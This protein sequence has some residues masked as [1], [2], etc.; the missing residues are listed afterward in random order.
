MSTSYSI[1]LTTANAA[2]FQQATGLS[3]SAWPNWARILFYGG[4]GFFTGAQLARRARVSQ[5]TVSRVLSWA[6]QTGVLVEASGQ[7]FLAWTLLFRHK[8]GLQLKNLEEALAMEG[9]SLG[10]ILSQMKRLS[11]VHESAMKAPS[12]SVSEQEQ[13]GESA[14]PNTKPDAG[15]ASQAVRGKPKQHQ[16]PDPGFVNAMD[17]EEW[18]EKRAEQQSAP[19]PVYGGWRKQTPEEMIASRLGI[20]V[21]AVSEEHMPWL[22]REQ[23]RS[24]TDRKVLFD[25]EFC[26]TVYRWSVADDPRAPYVLRKRAEEM[27]A[28]GQ[29][30]QP[31]HVTGWLTTASAPTSNENNRVWAT[32]CWEDYQAFVEDEAAKV[33]R[34]QQMAARAEDTSL[35]EEPV[36]FV[37]DEALAAF[38]EKTQASGLTRIAAWEEMSAKNKWPSYGQMISALRSLNTKEKL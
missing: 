31:H 15:Q 12:I 6:R 24:R 21:Q 3:F 10:E 28:H 8:A 2:V 16:A 32:T 11:N 13:E 17:R 20:P 7:Q 9:R 27:K 14:T 37:P 34:Q 19:A 30:L 5:A 22:D 38:Q 23:M 25:K 29:V 33:E 4:T 26:S 36:I 18:A 35:V 1:P